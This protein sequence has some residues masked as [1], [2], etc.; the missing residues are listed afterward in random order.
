[1]RY[2]KKTCILR[3][4]KNGFS[5]DG[6]ELSGIVKAEQYGSNVSI[7]FYANNLAPTNGQEYCLV[8]ADGAKTYKLLPLQSPFQNRF[9]FQTSMQLAGGFYAVVCFLENGNASPIAFGASGNLPYDVYSLCRHAFAS[10]V[11]AGAKTAPASAPVEAPQKSP[12][13]TPPEAQSGLPR[14]DVQLAVYDDE[15][16]A[17]ENYYEKEN[18]YES[19]P[20]TKN[21]EN[22]PPESGNQNQGQAQRNYAEQ[23]ANHESVRHAFTTE[24]D[25]YYQS[26]K[27]ELAL[28]FER[29]PADE[30]LTGAYPASEWVRV[31]GEK[32][33]PEEL[34][35]LIYESGLVKYICYA[36]PKRDDTPQEIREKGYFVPVSP[37]TPQTGYYVLYQSAATGE[38]IIKKES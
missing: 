29:Y 25:G 4:L 38:S 6:R 18:G 28:L 37:L 36:L 30:T 14:A 27:G 23:D 16:V 31:R 2:V 35:G 24:T 33:S 3:Q 9:T 5:T 8:V 34:V 20:H 13:P 21:C 10:D 26:I 22:A 32:D 1:M 15:R 11:K 17:S 12:A 7:E 19:N